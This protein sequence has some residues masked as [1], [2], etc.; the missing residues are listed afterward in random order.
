MKHDVRQGESRER[1]FM[2]LLRWRGGDWSEPAWWWVWRRGMAKSCAW[3]QDRV[4]AYPRAI[5][6]LGGREMAMTV[7][8]CERP[9]GRVGYVR[10]H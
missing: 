10:V 4:L 2:L 5:G 9:W 1:I 7:V 6:M 8:R 3:S